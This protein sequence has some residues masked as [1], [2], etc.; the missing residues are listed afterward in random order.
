MRCNTR[1]CAVASAQTIVIASGR[2]VS[3]SQRPIR[4]T[5]RTQGCRDVTRA[6]RRPRVRA[7][8]RDP[9][10][11]RT[12]K[13]LRHGHARRGPERHAISAAAMGQN[14]D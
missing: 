14:V 3:P 6:R 11:A 9:L 8:H 7:R 1:I 12:V 13:Q 4:I 5:A 10:V 2:P